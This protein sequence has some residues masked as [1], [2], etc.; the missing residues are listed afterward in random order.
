MHQVLLKEKQKPFWD[1][2]PLLKL[3][4]ASFC[5]PVNGFL[6]KR[7]KMRWKSF[8]SRWIANGKAESLWQQNYRLCFKLVIEELNS[9]KL[10]NFY[11]IV[12]YLNLQHNFWGI[13]SWKC[14]LFWLSC[15]EEAEVLAKKVRIKQYPARQTRKYY[16]RLVHPNLT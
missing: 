14:L 6:R 8:S 9:D 1:Y 11:F 15:W 10:G 16:P 7:I 13:F 3:K 2:F 4:N 5:C 12:D